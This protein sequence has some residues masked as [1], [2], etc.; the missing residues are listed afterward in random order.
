M[1]NPFSKRAITRYLKRFEAAFRTYQG[2]RPRAMYHDSYEYICNWSPELFADFEKNR[3]YRLQEELPALFG[4]ADRDRVA[5]VKY[6]YRR[7]ISD[8]ILH[9]FTESWVEWCHR[10]E[11]ATRDQAHG[12]PA[13]LLD[14]YGTCDI[15]ETEFFREQ[16]DPLFAKLASS[17]AHVMGRRLTASETG[18]WLNE[19]FQTTLGQMKELVDAF[20]LGGVNH[21]IYHGTCYSPREAPWPGWVFYASTQMNPRN[22]IWY[23]A[24]AL[25]AYITRCQ[26]VLQ[27]GQPDNDVLLYWGIHDVWQ[28]PEL[29]EQKLIIDQFGQWMGGSATGR[30]ARWLWQTGFAFDYVS[31]RQVLGSRPDGGAIVTPGSLR[32]RVVVVPEC[33][34]MPI[35]TLRGLIKLARGG[36]TVIFE[37][38]LPED[39]PGLA[40]LEERR[41]ERR[42]LC[43][44][45]RLPDTP[46]KVA[47]TRIGQGRVLVGAIEAALAAA[48][49]RR[50]RL[51]EQTGLQ[52]VRRRHEHGRYY[53]LVNRGK[54][55]IDGW[56]PLATGEAAAILMDPMSGHVGQAAVRLRHGHLQ[57]YVQLEPNAS[58]VVKTWEKPLEG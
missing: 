12:S 43:A 57:V 8:M 16:R 46:A 10:H 7:T 6:D 13:N 3:G 26:A 50:E 29:L 53:F 42:S 56:V 55:R 1:L 2:P 21:I 30:L 44:A 4:R 25:N 36:A 17:A 19:H 27:A 45:L 31:D 18:T 22:S 24:P 9:N 20:F 11:F 37:S 32:Y 34:L 15:P 28:K 47:T 52:F 51:V 39:V 23:D 41:A 38:R 5:R 58:V 35:E 54:Q 14:L 40:R 33:R 48:G 49:V